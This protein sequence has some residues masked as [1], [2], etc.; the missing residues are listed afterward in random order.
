MIRTFLT[1]LRLLG[2][3]HSRN[4]FVQWQNVRHRAHRSDREWVDL[5]VALGVVLFD[6]GEFGRAAEGLVVPVEVA[7]PPMEHVSIG[8]L[9]NICRLSYL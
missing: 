5:A 4:L 7:Q 9:Y 2:R 8:N 1:P 3:L 6:V